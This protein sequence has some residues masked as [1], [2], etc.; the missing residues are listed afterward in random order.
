[1]AVI[2]SCFVTEIILNP[3]SK[4]KIQ[5]SHTWFTFL[6][7]I[8]STTISPFCPHCLRRL[9]CF[10]HYFKS[11]NFLYPFPITVTVNLHSD[12][13][14]NQYIS[15]RD[16]FIHTTP[17]VDVASLSSG[18]SDKRREFVS[19]DY[20]S[21]RL[22]WEKQRRSKALTLIQS[23]GLVEERMIVS[24]IALGWSTVPSSEKEPQ[25]QIQ[26]PGLSFPRNK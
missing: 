7:L 18:T 22:T 2:T 8:L 13:I 20:F 1:M 3:A 17:L 15:F 23:N 25:P 24:L 5:I 11:N 4:S 16:S 12:I 21:L 26:W 9:R 19:R 6:S 10:T 14:S